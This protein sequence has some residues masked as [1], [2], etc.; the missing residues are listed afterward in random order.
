VEVSHVF[1]EDMVKFINE[2]IDLL[3]PNSLIKLSIEIQS[4]Y[5]KG[6]LLKDGLKKMENL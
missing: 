3:S 1:I 4:N 6:I 2:M 5:L